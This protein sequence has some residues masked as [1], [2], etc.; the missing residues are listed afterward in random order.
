M[1]CRNLSNSV[2]N[3]HWFFS[4]ALIYT[5][6]LCAGGYSRCLHPHML[7]LV[8]QKVAYCW[9]ITL[10]PLEDIFSTNQHNWDEQLKMHQ[11]LIH[12]ATSPFRYYNNVFNNSVKKV[13]STIFSD[14]CYFS[15]ITSS[16]RFWQSSI[17]KRHHHEIRRP[18]KYQKHQYLFF[19]KTK[20]IAMYL[21]EFWIQIE[22]KTSYFLANFTNC[23]KTNTWTKCM[24][25]YV[26]SS[27]FSL[28]EKKSNFLCKAM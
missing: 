28:Q 14:A 25:Y 6:R 15:H 3:S 21:S 2:P 4:P 19:K 18:K 24:S 20:V 13:H 16:I 11:N 10:K 12:K 7:C 27:L 5:L 17:A 23:T 8:F 22:H 9:N 26:R 1:H